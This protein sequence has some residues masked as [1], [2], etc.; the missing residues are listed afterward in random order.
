M[1]PSKGPLSTKPRAAPRKPSLTP[2]VVEGLMDL[3]RAVPTRRLKGDR[4]DKAA[5]YIL[6]L[7]DVFNDPAYQANLD[8]KRAIVNSSPSHVA[9]RKPK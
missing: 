7:H 3:L 4:M 6:C 5:Y 9:R 8:K 2:E 1:R